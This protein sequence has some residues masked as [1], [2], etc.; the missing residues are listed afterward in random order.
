[1]NI[2]QLQIFKVVCQNLSFTKAAKQLYMSQPAISHTI[3]DLETEIGCTLLDRINHKI[4]I[5]EAGY[6]FLNKANQ[7]LE[8]YDDLENHFLENNRSVIK[9]GSSI[10]I[11]GILLPAIIKEFQKQY[12]EI[13]IQ[14]IVDKAKTIETKLLSNEVD[15]AFIEGVIQHP[16]CISH[17]F[18][19]FNLLTVCSPI[20]PLAKKQKI[21]VD[22][23]TT[24]DLLLR[25]EGSAIRS[26]VNS[27]LLLQNKVVEPLWTSVNSQVLIQATIHNLGITIL[28]ETLITKELKERKL[29]KIEIENLSLSNHNYL[30]Y[31]KNK[32]IN[33]SVQLFIDFVLQS[34]SF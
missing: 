30:V 29:I 28:P 15:I 12:P 6:Q 14:V 11:A 31:H 20:H 18:S 2:R 24:T 16:M 3:S 13:Q 10:T 23:L 5:N 4:Y 17:S 25:E 22:D 8:L 27:A 33:S 32:S 21:T 9:V 19:K 1:M 7:I 34:A 26:C